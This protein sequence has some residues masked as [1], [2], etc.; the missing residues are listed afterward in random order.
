MTATATK[1]KPA[2]KAK[3][4]DCLKQADA[5]LRELHG[6]TFK[7]CLTMDFNT[8]QAGIAGPFLAIEWVTVTRGARKLPTVTCAFCPFCGKKKS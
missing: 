3:G 2:K 4:C 1:K 7:T 5:Q 6:A 8:M